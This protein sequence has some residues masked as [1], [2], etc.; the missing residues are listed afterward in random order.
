MSNIGPKTSWAARDRSEQDLEEISRCNAAGDVAARRR[1]PPSN[2]ALAA[3]STADHRTTFSRVVTGIC[4]TIA[5]E[6]SSIGRPGEAHIHAHGRAKNSRD[7]RPAS[8]QQLA[9]P[10]FGQVAAQRRPPCE[11]EAATTRTPCA[12]S[13]HAVCAHARGKG[14]PHMAAAGGQSNKNFCLILI[15]FLKNRDIRYNMAAIVLK[16]PSHSSDTNVGERWRIR[17]PSPGEAAEE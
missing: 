11:K 4:A 10:A 8:A 12:S 3:P 5:Q 14:P 9:R 1:P 16:D 7:T 6:I 13:A 2:R 17:I 15:Y